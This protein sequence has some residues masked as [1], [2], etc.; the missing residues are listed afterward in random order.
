MDDELQAALEKE[1]KANPE[2][3]FSISQSSSCSS[4]NGGNQICEVVSSLIMKCP[5]KKAIEVYRKSE[6]SD[7]LHGDSDSMLSKS[8]SWLLNPKSDDYHKDNNFFKIFGGR[9]VLLNI[10]QSISSLNK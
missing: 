2:C 9:Q 7:N 5:R 1:K 6:K 8:W 4:V 10:C 3:N